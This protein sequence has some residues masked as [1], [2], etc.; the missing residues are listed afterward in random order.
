MST[1]LLQSTLASLEKAV[2]RAKEML[3]EEHVKASTLLA[4]PEWS[5]MTP[6]ECAKAMEG[7]EKSIKHAKKNLAKAEKAQRLIRKRAKE[8][9]IE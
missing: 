7:H 4:S 8:Y 5:L 3:A 6:Q 9:G 1:D 2:A